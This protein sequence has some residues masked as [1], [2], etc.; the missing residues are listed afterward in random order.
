MGEILPGDRYMKDHFGGG[1]SLASRKGR[2]RVWE[3]WNNIGMGSC[4]GTVS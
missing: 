3:R 1:E 4:W 2:M